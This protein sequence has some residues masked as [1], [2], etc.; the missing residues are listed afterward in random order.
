MNLAA[1]VRAEQIRALY[2]QSR[3]VLWTN[4]AISAIVSGA[5]W[6]AAPR[7]SLLAWVG[8]MSMIAVGRSELTRRMRESHPSD[9]ELEVWSRRFVL[10]STVAGAAWG[11]GVIAFFDPAS[12]VS[13]LLLTFAIAGMTAAAAGTWA[14]H[15][16]VFWGYF[17]GSLGPLLA[18]TLAV[19]DP[20]HLAM[21]GMLGAYT[22]GMARVMRTNH[23]TLTEA[24]RLS[25]ENSGLLERLSL[26]RASLEDTNRTL[27]KRVTLR[28]AE[29][30][31][32]AEALRD[33][34][35]LEVVGRLAGGI[36]HDFNNP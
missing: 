22:V 33:A 35:R 28:T 18:R 1:A 3:P 25:F 14:S 36:A 24:F 32:Q 9:T 8:L 23:Q 4:V 16:P 19:G 10:G 15:P 29:L 7:P 12:A 13:Q 17:A 34:Q 11:L 31:R 20:A 21:A 26:S 27:E 30:E 5:L 2:R 6:Q